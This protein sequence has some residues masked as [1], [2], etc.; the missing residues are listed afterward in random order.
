[1]KFDSVYKFFVCL[2]FYKCER[3]RSHIGFYV[4]SLMIL[5]L[6]ITIQLDLDLIIIIMF[7]MAEF[8]NLMVIFLC[9]DIHI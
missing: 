3:F 2:K 7:H 6:H 8:Q 4:K 5:G 1:M 9:N